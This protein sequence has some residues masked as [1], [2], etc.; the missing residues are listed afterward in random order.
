MLQVA[1]W[2]LDRGQRHLD[3]YSIG[4]VFRSAPEAGLSAGLSA[5]LPA[6]PYQLLILRTRA[7]G[8]DFWNDS[9]ET[10]DLFDIKREI[11]ALCGR[12]GVDLVRRFSYRF[13]STT[14]A[15]AYGDGRRDLIHGGIVPARLAAHY[16]L[17][18][19]AWYAV[20]DLQAL[21]EARRRRSAYEPVPEYPPSKR[22]LSLVTPA[23]VSYGQ[24]EKSLVKNGGRLLESV[25]VFDV[26]QGGNMPD[27]S[28][29]YGVRLSFRSSEG[30]L[31]D[32]DVDTV[33]AKVIDKLQSELGVVLRS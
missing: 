1:R 2:N 32:A 31:T 6:E 29:A 13:E 28:T 11:E 19:A 3:L 21:F 26:F 15:F 12:F 18:Q 14:G 10:S 5:G 9:K 4:R 22:D 8:K 24:I 25:Q 30:T 16:D 7:E 20:I 27:G 23:G 17:D 33:L